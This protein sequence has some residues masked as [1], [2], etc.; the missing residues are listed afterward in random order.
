M[1]AGR[2]EAAYQSKFTM[3]RP[4]AMGGMAEILLA[5]VKGA[6]PE[7]LVVLKRLHRHLAAD[8]EHVEMFMDEA[9]LATTLRHTN[10]VEV[11]EAA[12]DSGQY[13]LVMEYLH[14]HDLR[15]VM[16]EMTKRSISIRLSQALAIIAGVCRGL[17]YTH[18]RTSSGGELLGVVHRDVS[19]H[20]VLI[21]F[22]GGVKLLDFG[23]A[24]ASGQMSRTRTG[25]LKGKV[26]YM[27]PE[28]AMGDEL[29]RRSDVFC[30]GILLWEMTTGQWLYRR[31][32]E[33]ETL[34]AVVESDAPLPST[35]YPG[36]PRELEQIVMKTLARRREDRWSSAGELADAIT[37]FAAKQQLPLAPVTL[38]RMMNS[39]FNEESAAWQDARRAGSTLGD[40]LVAELDREERESASSRKVTG[41]SDWR[42]L[43]SEPTAM[44]AIN[45][46]Q[47]SPEE[48]DSPTVD[49]S[50][51]ELLLP[52]VGS[53]GGMEDEPTTVHQQ[54]GGPP[55]S[56]P[57]LPLPLPP[58]RPT[59]PQAAHAAAA[60]QV[61]AG[62]AQPAQPSQPRRGRA[63]LL[64][65]TVPPPGTEKQPR[66]RQ[67]STRFMWLT[68]SAVL[69]VLAAIWLAFTLPRHDAQPPA[70]AAVTPPAPAPAAPAL[71][72]AIGSAAQPRAPSAPAPQ[73]PAVVTSP[74]SVITVPPARTPPSAAAP[75]S[76]H[77]GSGSDAATSSSA[78][79]VG[80]P[81]TAPKANRLRP[82]ASHTATEAKPVEPAPAGPVN[83]TSP[84]DAAPAPVA[85]AAP[86]S[87][88]P[89]P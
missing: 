9:R 38:G 24:K 79:S 12:E 80:R 2:T 14:G 32:S 43:S 73:P 10:V 61:A 89:S 62:S 53:L 75:A 63:T 28:Q 74:S 46:N 68:G 69:A 29:D 87:S 49:H 60:R 66:V 41:V 55:H 15:R 71:P 17:D 36:Y 78:T 67:M 56:Q 34:K 4:L 54:R 88:Q 57:G 82:A 19:P 42:A 1:S 3:L 52:G 65:R 5:R 45:N 83:T 33:L 58:P 47:I 86:A 70:P 23:I 22:N 11:Y 77:S 81:T 31:K 25:I 27:S 50:P 39:L 7:R 30:V 20:N 21:T 16:Q 51:E 48:F 44:L 6:S 85:P 84:P 40:H 8:Q 35:L 72:A 18:D 59:G 13:Y 37:S 64:V 76:P 26:A